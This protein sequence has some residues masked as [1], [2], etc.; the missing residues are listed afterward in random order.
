MQP[1]NANTR[2]GGVC[3]RVGTGSDDA[4]DDLVPWDYIRQLRRKFALDDVQI[5]PADSAGA[6]LNDNFIRSR[7]RVRNFAQ[8]ER[9]LCNGIRMLQ[10]DRSHNRTFAETGTGDF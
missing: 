8:S 2:A 5:R 6:H 9:V 4:A 3:L 7:L 10:N 1:G